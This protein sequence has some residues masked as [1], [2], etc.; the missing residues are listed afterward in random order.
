MDAMNQTEA[1]LRAIKDRV[2]AVMGELEEAASN[3]TRKANQQR[4]RAAADQLHRCADDMQNVLMHLK[5]RS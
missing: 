2:A 5:P 1:A 4:L 3:T